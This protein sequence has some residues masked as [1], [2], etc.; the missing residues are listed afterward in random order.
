MALNNILCFT[1][2]LPIFQTPNR[3]LLR[4]NVLRKREVA[5]MEN[6]STF[7]CMIHPTRPG[8]VEEMLAEEVETMQAHSAYLDQMMKETTFHLIGPCLD[9]AFGVS[10]FEAESLEVACQIAAHDP[11]VERGVM[12]AEV[13][14]F[15][16]SFWRESEI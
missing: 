13:H 5:L 14:P 10:I 3:I 4:E 8:F 7:I 6:R 2:S 11:A 1:T 16:I 9:R 15:R 12:S